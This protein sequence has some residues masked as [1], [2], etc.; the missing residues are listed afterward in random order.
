MSVQKKQQG[1]ARIKGIKDSSHENSIN[2]AET[3]KL[4]SA[5]KNFGDLRNIPQDHEE[6]PEVIEYSERKEP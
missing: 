4:H 3:I 1:D 2:S 6:M 5:M